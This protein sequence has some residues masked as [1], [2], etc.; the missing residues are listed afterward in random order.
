[1]QAGFQVR[2]RVQVSQQNYLYTFGICKAVP[3]PKNCLNADGSSRVRFSSA[4]AWQTSV[5]DAE[6]CKY[7]GSPDK[8]DH[9]WAAIDEQDPAKGVK[10]T[11]SNGQHCSNGQ[12]RKFA[13]NFKCAPRTVET[14]EQRVIDESR[15]CE[16]EIEI[17]SEYACPT[18]CGLIATG[19]ICGSHG[20]CGFDTTTKQA[21]CFC[22]TGRTGAHCTE[23]LDGDT[24][25]SLQPVIGLL[26]FVV[27]ALL[28][29]G[30]FLVMLWRH[31]QGRS[32]GSMYSALHE[33]DGGRRDSFESSNML[34]VELEQVDQA[35][36]YRAQQVV[37]VDASNT[38][39]NSMATQL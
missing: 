23:T 13:L 12:Q 1:M 4:P 29:L 27:V 20:L 6:D 30:A 8:A 35:E 11:Y 32:L 36:E 38:N 21:K 26:V 18:E 31:V 16:Y 14:I 5:S 9:S 33:E 10:L 2:D 25:D 28:G 17:E 24:S 34:R 22:N 19:A 39:F 15:H 37:N 3:A 7:L